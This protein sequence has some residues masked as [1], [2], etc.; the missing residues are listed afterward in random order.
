MY[1]KKAN[2]KNSFGIIKTDGKSVRI[3]S[4]TVYCKFIDYPI[5]YIQITETVRMSYRVKH[6]SGTGS[7]QLVA[8]LASGPCG[9]EPLVVLCGPDLEMRALNLLASHRA[10]Y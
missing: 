10:A 3:E 9:R 8:S 6:Q 2:V 1:L 7:L 5:H 4:V